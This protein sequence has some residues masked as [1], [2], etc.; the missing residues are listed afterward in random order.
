MRPTSVFAATLV[1]GAGVLAAQ[2]P[3]PRAAKIAVLKLQEAILS[4]EEGQQAVASMHARFDPRKIALDRL[5]ADLESK[6]T[7]LDRGLASEAG[8]IKL[9][10]E[11]ASGTRQLKRDT[12]D[13]DAEV[14]QEESRIEREMSTKMTAVIE[15]YARQRGY[16]LVLD[17]SSEQTPVLWAATNI[18]S[19]IIKAYDTAHP[20]LKSELPAAAPAL[21]GK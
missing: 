13:L 16:V 12:E 1:F 10:N 21:P 5:Q 19:D 15:K 17:G 3:A 18:T 7:Q 11:I 2:T 20:V 6:Q 9:A 8:R 4:T 14:Q